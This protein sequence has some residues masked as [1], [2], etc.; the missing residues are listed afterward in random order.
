MS[1]V[2]ERAAT[3]DTA[4][5]DAPVLHA[6]EACGIE[7]EYALVDRASLDVRPIA[8]RALGELAGDGDPVAEVARGMFGWSNELALHVLELKNSDPT[9]PME[10]LAERFQYELDEM[11][12]VLAAHGA[13][14]LP[15][16][17]HPWMEPRTETRLWPHENAGI[18]RTYDR[19]FDCRSHGYANLQSMHVNL[20]FAGDEEFARLHDAV[21]LVLPILPAIAASSPFAEGRRAPALDYRMCVYRDNAAAVP[22][23]TAAVVP[24]RAASRADYER[25]ILA[26]MYRAIGQHD[27]SGTLCSEWLNA[28]GAIARFERSAIEIRV[29]DTQECPRM[30]VALAALV[31]DL[32]QAIYEGR[33]GSPPMRGLATAELAAILSAC[34]AEGDDAEIAHPAYLQGF[35]IRRPRLRARELWDAIGDRLGETHAARR[36]LWQRPFAHIQ[37]RGTLARRLLAAAGRAP[38]R[39]QLHRT[40]AALCEALDAGAAFD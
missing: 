40:Y 5:V 37:T 29:L 35:G 23:I 9:V 28:R 32:V 2:A 6:F 20:P 21:R 12:A 27:R 38:T 11:N 16:G 4:S 14:L 25:T 13:R 17:M 18:Y 10:M 26:P 39:A 1:L 33:I 8:D 31:I 22:E 34:I 15:G 3:L 24:E 36:A 19:I 30:D 7:L